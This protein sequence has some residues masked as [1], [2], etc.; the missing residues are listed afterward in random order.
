METLCLYLC[1]IVGKQVLPSL[2]TVGQGFPLL[3][4]QFF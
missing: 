3:A 2:E 1:Q 4:P